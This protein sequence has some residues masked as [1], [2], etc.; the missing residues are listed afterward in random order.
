MNEMNPSLL[1][2]DMIE[3]K[4]SKRELNR[5]AAKFRLTQLNSLTI[6]YEVVYKNLVRDIRKYFANDFNA[7]NLLQSRNYG[8]SDFTQFLT[9]YARI[10][11]GKY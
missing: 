2:F 3:L 8:Q 4:K 1:D 7:M 6:R 11:L 10:T 9:L 5:N